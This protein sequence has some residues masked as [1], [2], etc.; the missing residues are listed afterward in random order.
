LFGVLALC[1]SGVLSSIVFAQQSLPLVVYPAKQDIIVKAGELTNAQIQFRNKSDKPVFGNVKVVDFIINDKNGTPELVEKSP[2]PKYGAANWIT[3]SYDVITIPPNDFVSINLQIKVPA[4]V[5][6]CGKYALVYFEPNLNAS[7]I[8]STD[9]GSAIAAKIGGI[10]NLE[11][12]QAN[13]IESATI[14]NTEYNQFQE[15]GPI[16]VSYDIANAGNI[17]INPSGFIQLVNFFGEVVDQKNI[18]E[19]R[20]FP[21]TIRVFNTELGTKWMAGKY[22]VDLKTGY[23]NGKLLTSTINIWVFPWRL[24]IVILIALIIIFFIGRELFKKFIIKE[25]KLEE[26]L[27]KNKEE[28]EILKEKL[29]NQRE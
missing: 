5:T 20:I 9:G 28:I 8:K 17:H 18:K 7:G 23:G 16:K 13:C 6:T 21:E 10:I 11:T 3:S 1:G 15:Y 26:E 14:S 2:V 24:A 27:E 19:D 4:N 12:S 25:E 22:K 29:R